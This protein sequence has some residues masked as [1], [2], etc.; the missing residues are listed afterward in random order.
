MPETV[1]RLNASENRAA[2]KYTRSEMARRALWMAGQWLLRLSPRPA[3]GWRRFV[4][5]LFGATI[6]PEVHVYPTTVIYMPWNL[7]VGAWSAIAEDALIY[8]LGP[9]SIGE[10]VTVSHR[11][12][13]CAGT[14]DH[15]DPAFPLLKPPITVHDQ[16]WVCSEAFVG[17]GVTVG[18]G[19]VVAA[20]A[21]AVKDVAP[22]SIVVGNPARHVQARD[23]AA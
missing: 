18:E 15:T 12:H 14:H 19:A 3:F 22:W 2:R 9:V 11:A 7:S 23:L 13:L 1:V 8:N 10:R 5:R 4:L 21:V 6:G 20:R 16:A 17:P